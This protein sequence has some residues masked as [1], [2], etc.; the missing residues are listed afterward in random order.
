MAELEAKKKRSRGRKPK[1]V[2][3]SEVSSNKK[4]NNSIKKERES[5]KVDE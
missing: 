4:I 1:N 5:I 2:A 3:T